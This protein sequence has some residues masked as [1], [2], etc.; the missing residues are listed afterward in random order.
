MK[1][2]IEISPAMREF[3]EAVEHADY[4]TEYRFDTLDASELNHHARI[5]GYSV[6]AQLLSKAMVD[7]A[8]KR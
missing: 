6:A 1:T 2:K 7:L 5:E 4:C 8:I 3:N